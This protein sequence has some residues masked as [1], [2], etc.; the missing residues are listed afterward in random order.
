MP[1]RRDGRRCDPLGGGKAGMTVPNFLVIGAAKAGT[2]SLR[3]YLDQHP[4]VFVSRRREP[5][6]FAHAGAPPRC[7]GPGDDDWVFVTD[8]T[9]YRRLF[10]EAAGC[11]AVGEISPRYLYFEQASARIRDHL[12]DVRLVAVLRHPVDRAY[13]H[14]LMNRGRA[15]EPVADFPEA[16]A[17]EAQRRAL[18]WGWDWC[19]IG[20]GL[21]HRQLRRYFEKFPRRQIGVFLYDDYRRAPERFLAEIF[22]FLGVARSFAP[23]M[24][25]RRREAGLPRSHRLRRTLDGGGSFKSAVGRLLP[26]A[27]RR[28]AKTT[29]ATWNT[30]RP[31]PLPVEQRRRLFEA[32]F[33]EDCR[34]LSDLI[35]RDLSPWHAPREVASQAS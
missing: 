7:L 26:P 34:R 20:A 22:E 21:Y 35:E 32:R 3:D 5:S 29:L 1:V 14:F 9:D 33:A 11:S 4:E 24:S 31:A 15:C 28:R 6:F 18:G 25:Q 30:V 17:L 16:M 8:W 2:T 10:D 12:P 19:Y 27:W 23:D 13:S